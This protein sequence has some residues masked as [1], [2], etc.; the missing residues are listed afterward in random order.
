MSVLAII[1]LALAALQP[2]IPLLTNNTAYPKIA[3][4]IEAAI[5]SL[6]NAQQ[7]IINEQE[8]ESLRTHKIW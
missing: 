7:A 4:E 2:L 5:A 8:L 6:T 1:Q 3:S